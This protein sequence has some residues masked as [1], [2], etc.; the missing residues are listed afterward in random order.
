[1]KDNI[2]VI[3]SVIVRNKFS[4][5]SKPCAS[6]HA[7]LKSFHL[8]HVNA[9]ANPFLRK[10]QKKNRD[11]S[12]FC[13]FLLFKKKN[14]FFFQQQNK[15]LCGSYTCNCL[16]TVGYILCYKH[17][18]SCFRKYTRN[19]FNNFLIHAKHQSVIDFLQR[20]I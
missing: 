18:K 20:F 13:I 3:V 15:W 6:S 16:Y 2:N 12:C 5:I 19:F 9:F 1:M 17:K 14:S 7:R 4:L 11:S 8:K 10:Q